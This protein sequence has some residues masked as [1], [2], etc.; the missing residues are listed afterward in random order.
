MVVLAFPDSMPDLAR[1]A[2]L[3]LL[4]EIA[5]RTYVVADR[6]TVEDS[7]ACGQIVEAMKCIKSAI[8]APSHAMC[9][10][11]TTMCTTAHAMLKAILPDDYGLPEDAQLDAPPV[12]VADPDAAAQ[13]TAANATIAKLSADL[14]KTAQE[15]ETLKATPTGRS[16]V[17]SQPGGSSEGS[18]ATVPVETYYENRS[19]LAARGARAMDRGSTS[20]ARQSAQVKTD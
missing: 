20:D 17:R 16:T 18:E 13:L 12:V 3:A 8:V 5:G 19:L 15:L 10:E 14:E 4:P 1:S 11:P 7:S 6:K 2:L 9:A